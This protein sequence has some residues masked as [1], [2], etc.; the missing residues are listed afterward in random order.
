VA[1]CAHTRLLAGAQPARYLS[2]TPAYR[3]HAKVVPQAGAYV[4]GENFAGADGSLERLPPARMVWAVLVGM[5]G[6][7]RC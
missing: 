1:L 4:R 5:K 7:R 2:P 3:Q 6:V